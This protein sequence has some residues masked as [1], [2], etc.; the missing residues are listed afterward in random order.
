M[1][2]T[3]HCNNITSSKG[4][5]VSFV[6]HKLPPAEGLVIWKKKKKKNS[7]KLDLVGH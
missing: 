7:V 1:L 4:C 2:P 5:K 3:V 6:V